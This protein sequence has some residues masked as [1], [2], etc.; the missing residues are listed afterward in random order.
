MLKSGKIVACVHGPTVLHL[1][2]LP[3]LQHIVIVAAADA[4]LLLLVLLMLLLCCCSATLPCAGSCVRAACSSTVCESVCLHCWRCFQQHYVRKG[5]CRFAV[6]GLCADCAQVA[7]ASE[8][9]CDV[10]GA[11]ACAEQCFVCT[12]SVRACVHPEFGPCM[13]CCVASCVPC[14]HSACGFC[15]GSRSGVMVF[16]VTVRQAAVLQV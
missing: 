14:L 1:V 2:A 13:L 9:F 8:L 5:V 12:L 6:R 10:S 11:H 4:L 7:H 15:L 16:P 3:Q